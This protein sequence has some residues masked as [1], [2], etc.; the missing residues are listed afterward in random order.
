MAQHNEIV[1]EDELCAYLHAHGWLYSPDDTGYDRERA[2]YPADVLGWLH[3][4][5]PDQLAKVIKTTGPSTTA[6]QGQL[7]DRIVKVLDT[8]NGQRRWHPQ[9]PPQ[10]LRRR[11]D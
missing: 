5:Q 7:L 2:L 11:A 8:P 6:Q 1:F 3:D 9:P 10:G 4:T